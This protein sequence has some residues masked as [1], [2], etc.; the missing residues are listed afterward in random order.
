MSIQRSQR[1]KGN[2]WRQIREFKR[3]SC[4]F[5]KMIKEVRTTTNALR[6]A[7]DIPNKTEE[8]QRTYTDWREDWKKLESQKF[9]KYWE[10][11]SSSEFLRVI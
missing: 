3:I 9:E 8:P 7:L 5:L 1:S 6:E 4:F 10:S 11:H 2:H